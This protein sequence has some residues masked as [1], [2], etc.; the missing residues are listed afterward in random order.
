MVEMSGMIR[1]KVKY[2][3]ELSDRDGDG[4]LDKVGYVAVRCRVDVQS[5]GLLERGDTHFEKGIK[6]IL[7]IPLVQCRMSLGNCFTM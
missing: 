4:R 7:T 3:F 1:D 6:R 2:M 5:F